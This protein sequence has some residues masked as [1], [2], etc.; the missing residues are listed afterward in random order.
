MENKAVFRK[1]CVAK[2]SK[3]KQAR[4]QKKLFE[5]KHE[6][7]QG[8]IGR[9]EYLENTETQIRRGAVSA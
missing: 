9:I 6:T 7:E 5:K 1:D 4:N 8:G 3:S 2:Y